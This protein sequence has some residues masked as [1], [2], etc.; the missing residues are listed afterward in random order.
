MCTVVSSDSSAAEDP[1]AVWRDTML[2]VF[3]AAVEVRP[4]PGIPFCA[5]ARL[6]PLGAVQLLR[7]EGTRFSMRCS[8]VDSA[9]D[10][11]V[12][13]PLEGSCLLRQARGETLMDGSAFF[14]LPTSGEAEFEFAGGFDFV[15][16]GLTRD[17]LPAARRTLAGGTAL[18]VPV[19]TDPAGLFI[20]FVRALA[21][22][23][24]DL[25]VRTCAKVVDTIL[26]LLDDALR[27]ASGARSRS[28]REWLHRERIT[29]VV[30]REL[31]NPAL[32]IPYIARSVGLSPRHVH[33]LFADDTVPLMQWVLELRLENC[34]REL[35]HEGPCGRTIGEIAYSWGFND[36]A[37]FSRAFRRRFGM[38]PSAL[39][40]APPAADAA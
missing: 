36:Q 3:G 22:N 9:S 4:E 34:Y 13:V 38:T 7:L 19:T 25:N 8:M 21:R 39:R 1:I 12:V 14:I 37:H 28:N 35:I 23:H 11:F 32:D 33:R 15:A 40:C 31:R 17:R 24:D 27:R 5:V 2:S 26:D 30:E 20:G 18:R 16:L 29:S 6:H 10:L